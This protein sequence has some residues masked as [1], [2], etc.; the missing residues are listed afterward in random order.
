MSIESLKDAISAQAQINRFLV[1][2]GIKDLVGDYGE[3]LVHKAF[4]G[5]RE[6]AVNKGYDIKHP[7]YGR[8]EVKTRK[9]EL[10]QDGTIRKES[11]AVGFKGK[12]AGFDWLAHVVLDV[13]FS[14]ISACLASYQE[15]WPEIQRT[16]DKVGYSTSSRL[17]SSVDIRSKVKGAQNELGF[18]I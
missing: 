2:N 8:I 5:S 4:G 18:G 14:V 9:Y 17:P 13:D 3:M 12:E 1:S 11:R 7:E 15:I 16:V 10:L 6:N